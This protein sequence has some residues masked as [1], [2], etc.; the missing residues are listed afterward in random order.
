MDGIKDVEIVQD[1]E[2]EMDNISVH[3][4]DQANPEHY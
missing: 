4:D 2:V 1:E 3:S